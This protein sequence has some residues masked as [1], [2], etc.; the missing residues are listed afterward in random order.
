MAEMIQAGCLVF[1][2]AGGGQREIVGA[3]ERLLYRDVDDA[4]AKIAA[5]LD[6]PS[7]Q[8]ALHA[9]LASHRAASSL[10]HFADRVRTIV[11]EFTP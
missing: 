5:V 9:A 1:V 11:A 2:P 10:E 8:G 6:D 3:G 4:A 7:V